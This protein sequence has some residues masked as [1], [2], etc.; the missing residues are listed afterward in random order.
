MIPAQRLADQHARLMSPYPMRGTGSIVLIAFPQLAGATF[1]LVAATGKPYY[2]EGEEGL[3][4]PDLTATTL[5]WGGG[6]FTEVTP[7]DHQINLGG[8][9]QR[10]IAHPEL[11]WPSDDE[12][13]VRMPVG[14][15]DSG[16]CVLPAL[17]GYQRQP[18]A[19]AALSAAA[20]GASGAPWET[21][22]VSST[23]CQ[24]Q[25][26]CQCQ[27]FSAS[28]SVSL[29]AAPVPVPVS[30]TL[31]VPVPSVSDSRQCLAT[32]PVPVPVTRPR[33]HRPDQNLSSPTGLRAW[34]PYD[35]LSLHLL[36]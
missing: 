20:V 1:E 22:S 16:Q 25:C 7:G 8:T 30:A 11:G 17:L 3:W 6:G 35:S 19:P 9:A 27:C 14:L 13:S 4:N 32:V 28:A 26:Q 23:G 31:P 21:C 5:P 2:H 18:P 24:C 29:V 33:S 12:N 36:H 15:R 10:C 34:R